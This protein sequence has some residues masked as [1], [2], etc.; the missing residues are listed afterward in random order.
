MGFN[1]GLIKPQVDKRTHVSCV[2]ISY[3]FLQFL[4]LHPDTKAAHSLTPIHV[5]AAAP[6][7]ATEEMKW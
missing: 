4:Y 2:Y 5:L 6:R 1:S 3:I 7:G